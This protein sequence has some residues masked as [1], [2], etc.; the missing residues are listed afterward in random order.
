MKLPETTKAKLPHILASMLFSLSIWLLL[1]AFVKYITLW[2][3]QLGFSPFTIPIIIGGPLNNPLLIEMF[4]SFIIFISM[5]LL[6]TRV[7]FYQEIK[8][9]IITFTVMLLGIIFQFLWNVSISVY[10]GL[11]P[12]IVNHQNMIFFDN[13]ALEQAL[14]SNTPNLMLFLLALPTLFL[15]LIMTWLVKLCN[16]HWQD[17]IVFF[18]DFKYNLKVP[19]FATIF[20]SDDKKRRVAKDIKDFFEEKQ[21][22]IIPLPDVAI[23]PNKKTEAMVIQRG[24]DRTL[25]NLIIGAIGTG[26]TSALLLPLINQD[27]HHTTFM[28]NNYKKY[29]LQKDYHSED[30]KGRFFN[31]ISV[32]E[33]S[34]DLCDKT[35]QL[36]KAH[37]IPEEVVFYIDPT[38][39]ETPSLNLFKGPT[40]KVAE[41]FTMVVSG[42]GESQEFFFEQSQRA[43][44]KMHIYLLKE[45]EP[46]AGVGFEDLINMYND[47]Q[48]VAHMH[49]KLKARLSSMGD[50]TAIEDRDERNSLLILKGISE[51]FDVSYVP[52][53]KGFGKNVQADI[54]KEGPYRGQQRVE[55]KKSEHVVGLRNILNDI[56]SNILL[57]RVLF[58]QSDFDFDKHLEYG[59]ILLVNTAKGELSDLS[60]VLGKFVLL[61]LQSAVFRRK[62]NDSPY[63][64]IIVDEFPDYINENFGSFPA[65][66]RKYKAI[67]T[68]VAQTVSQ[69]QRKYGPDFMT[70][71][72]ATLRNKFVYGDGTQLDAEMFSSIFGEKVIFEESETDQEVSPLMDS[73]NRRTGK[74]YSKADRATMTVSEM[75]YQDA[76]VAAVKLVEDNK[77]LQAQQVK[78]NFVSK[79]EFNQAEVTVET[80]AAKYWLDIRRNS[81][82]GISSSNGTNEE[83]TSFHNTEAIIE[84]EDLNIALPENQTQKPLKSVNY[85][86]LS[87]RVIDQS[88]FSSNEISSSYPNSNQ[89]EVLYTQTKPD[90]QHNMNFEAPLQTEQKSNVETPLTATSESELM[91]EWL[92]GTDPV[93]ETPGTIEPTI[94]PTI[95]KDDTFSN[96]GLDS[97]NTDA[98]IKY[99]GSGLETPS[100]ESVSFNDIFNNLI[101]ETTIENREVPEGSNTELTAAINSLIN[102]VTQEPT[103]KVVN[104]EVPIKKEEIKEETEISLTNPFDDTIIKPIGFNKPTE[105]LA[106]LQL[107]PLNNELSVTPTIDEDEEQPA[108]N[109]DELN[110]YEQRKKE[111]QLQ[112]I[113]ESRRKLT[114]ERQIKKSNSSKE[115]QKSDEVLQTT[116]NTTLEKVKQPLEDESQREREHEEWKQQQIKEKRN[117]RKK[118]QI[119]DLGL[120]NDILGVLSDDNKK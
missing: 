39:P 59:G 38:N 60:D 116:E 105:E 114:I 3:L 46:D 68:V 40:D 51:W 77:P 99:H 107:E 96:T 119:G 74:S 27:L 92:M 106:D 95:V 98:S 6:S 79:A 33:P 115:V 21:P 45:H 65:Q 8:M 48:L 53:E 76:F 104:S 112:R 18:Q 10:Q 1:R 67:I 35:F 30:V 13:N 28:I 42:I 62:P 108:E 5:W 14:F 103:N 57:R 29:Y 26:K 52:V 11:I 55:D 80:E 72:V 49:Q 66:S 69:L 102:G 32:I 43:H 61:S 91:A 37:G 54:I 15:F 7:K 31:G 9:R 36:V 84:D 87:S 34:K 47:A 111:V 70:T 44:L 73:P 75:I 2:L 12:F 50:V 56:A 78:A 94:E 85:D 24:K 109:E 82:L 97:L 93:D 19:A 41:M 20:M 113:E 89:N 81:L 17:L 16:E 100:S 22:D 71:L 63:H 86:L 110:S 120:F 64:H 25:N 4:L 117:A 83:Q 90:S 101:T 58:G 23:G 118:T 88:M